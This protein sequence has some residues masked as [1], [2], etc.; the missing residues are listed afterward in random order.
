AAARDVRML[1]AFCRCSDGL[2]VLR[3]LSFAVSRPASLTG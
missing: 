2:S 1:V 3:S